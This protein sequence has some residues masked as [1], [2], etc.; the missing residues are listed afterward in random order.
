[1][2]LALAPET[3]LLA[4]MVVP[5]LAAVA[6]PIFHRAPNAREAVTLVSAAAVAWIVWS[7]AGPIMSGARPEVIGFS[8]LPGLQFA[9]Q[10]EPLGMLFALVAG[11]LWIVNSVYSIGYMRAHDEPR[12]TTFYVCF[13]V[14]IGSAMGLAFSKNLFTLFVFYE[15]LTLSTY[16]LVAHKANR[17]AIVGARIYL[18]LLLGTSMMLLLP[19]IVG[20]WMLAGTTE[21]AA[22]GILPAGVDK[23]VVAILLALYAFGIGKAG[24]MPF[25]FWLPSAMVAPTPVSALL[26][27]VAV[28]KAGVFTILKVAVYIFGTERLASSGASEWLVGVASVSLLGASLVALMQTNLKARL[29]YS[30]VSQ[31][32]YI[33]LAAALATS[34]GVIGGAMHIVMHAAGKITLFFCAGAIYVASHKTDISELDGIGRRMPWTMAA[35]F[36]ASLSIIGLPPFGGVWSKWAIGMGA[37]DAG[38]VFVVGV[39]MASSL[40]N[41][42]YLLPIVVRAFFLPEKAPAHGDGHATD[43]NGDHAHDGHAHE[44]GEAPLA[45]V[46]PLTLTALACIV[47][48]VTAGWV[49]ALVQPLVATGGR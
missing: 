49:E 40:L 42:A 21:F 14:A 47:L 25:H 28:V 20:T 35:F 31:L 8:V 2:R 33:V 23:S 39:L 34:A 27:A 19:A 15:L 30:T 16:P 36:L 38:H 9:F 10:I 43:A 6:L 44:H 18:S 46:V 11:T 12:Q 45:C 7:L 3:L 1:M 32:A 37:L 24:L 48:F 22:G 26:H 29:A 4:A 17:E 13:A 5:F 41:V